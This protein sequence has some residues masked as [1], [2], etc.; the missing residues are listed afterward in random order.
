MSEPAGGHIEHLFMLKAL[1][2]N[3]MSYRFSDRPKRMDSGRI[4]YLHIG[5]VFN[6]DTSPFTSGIK[7]VINLSNEKQV[8]VFSV[9]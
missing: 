1:G 2:E 5:G 7:G 6:A 4:S 3:E 9:R 8:D